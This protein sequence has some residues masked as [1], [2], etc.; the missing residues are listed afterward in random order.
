MWEVGVTVAVDLGVLSVVIATGVD[1]RW[2]L[3]FVAARNRGLS[4]L[5]KD[6]LEGD[7]ESGGGGGIFCGW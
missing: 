5:L 7:L 2:L 1:K 4:G 6:L 3:S